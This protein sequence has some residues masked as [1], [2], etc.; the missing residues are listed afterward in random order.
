MCQTFIIE[1]LL[2]VSALWTVPNDTILILQ[3][4]PQDFTFF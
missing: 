1:L 2:H 3:E 4:D